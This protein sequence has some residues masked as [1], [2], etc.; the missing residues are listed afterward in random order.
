MFFVYPT[1][2][3][4]KSVHLVYKFNLKTRDLDLLRVIQI[5]VLQAIIFSLVNKYYYYI[6]ILFLCYVFPFASKNFVFLL[7]R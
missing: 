7:L 3:D 6:A 1:G 2:C 4:E 5:C